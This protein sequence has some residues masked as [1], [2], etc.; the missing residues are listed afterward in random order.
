MILT[1]NKNNMSRLRTA[2]GAASLM[3][4]SG[5]ASAA[6]EVFDYSCVYPLISAQPL[7]LNIDVDIPTEVIVGESVPII[8]IDIVANLLGQTAAGLAIVQGQTLE[9]NATLDVVITGPGG[10]NHSITNWD[11]TG[12]GDFDILGF[13]IP[14]STIPASG[15]T[16]NLNLNGDTGEEINDFD[17]S[18]IGHA[19]ITMPDDMTLEIIVKKADGSAVIFAESV[20]ASGLF[21]VPC[22][23]DNNASMILGELDLINDTGVQINVSP[24]PHNYGA[25]QS[26]LSESQIFTVSNIGDQL[27]VVDSVDLSGNSRFSLISDGCSNVQPG[28][29]CLVRV[30]YN[31]S[32][33]GIHTASLMIL[34]NADDASTIVDLT[35]ESVTSVFSTLNISPA[36]RLSFDD[37]PVGESKTLAI[38]ISNSGNADLTATYATT[39]SRFQVEDDCDTVEPNDSCQLNVTYTPTAET[40]TNAFLTIFSND[41]SDARVEFPLIGTGDD[42]ACSGVVCI[43]LDIVGETFIANAGGYPPLSGLIQ[44]KFDVTAGTFTADLALD[45]TYGEFPLLGT[46]LGTAA[47][48]EFSQVGKTTGT[49]S[50]GILTANAEMFILLPDIYIK[51]FGLK[52]R[53]GGGDSCST[54]DAA[55]MAMISPSSEVFDPLQD[56][57]SLYAEYVLPNTTRCGPFTTIIN[58][59]MAGDGNTMDIDLT[60]VN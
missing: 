17:A 4:A 53:I 48:I 51:I 5:M 35:G 1:A 28:D 41:P 18:N 38:T 42:P 12:N 59:I 25:V 46:W 34:S 49:L 37:V 56:G 60:P 58:I 2:I 43:D 57:G 50:G 11:S 29:D 55:T 15:S 26:G 20:D 22:T 52:I 23:E 6:T 7:T 54:R 21:I 24:A 3:M 31:A 32:G 36:D 33:S 30:D 9:G 27:L 8:D 44:A 40:T 45:P 13:D 16:F 10:Y 19:I 14:P 47:E 39:N